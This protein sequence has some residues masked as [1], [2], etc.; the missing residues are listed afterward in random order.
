MTTAKNN[1]ISKF[2]KNTENT[3]KNAL[4]SSKRKKEEDKLTYSITLN[5]T[6]KEGEILEKNSGIARVS[7]YLR[8]VLRNE[9][10]VFKK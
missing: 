4:N 3:L 9:T 1:D 2:T 10:D 8:H 7:D 6:E 5:L